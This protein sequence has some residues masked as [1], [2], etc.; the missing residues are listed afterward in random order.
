MNES[1]M[2]TVFKEQVGKSIISYINEKKMQLAVHL[3]E[4]T[5]IY[6]KEVAKQVGITDPFY[7]NRLFKKYYGVTPSKYKEQIAAGKGRQS[8]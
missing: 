2:C 8:S 4:N 7:F 6:I 3:I 5:D 1:Y